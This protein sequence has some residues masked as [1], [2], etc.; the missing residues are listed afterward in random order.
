MKAGELIDTAQGYLTAS[1]TFL[2]MAGVNPVL[3]AGINLGIDAAQAIIDR[4]AGADR[5]TDVTQEE[6]NAEADAAIARTRAR[7]EKYDAI[8][9]ARAEDESGDDGTDE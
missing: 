8:D 7:T 6:I 5:E 3:I 9:A 4:W 2:A 1:E